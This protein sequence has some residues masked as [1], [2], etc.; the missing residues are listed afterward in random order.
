MEKRECN[1][2]EMKKIAK[3]IEFLDDPEKRGDIPPEKLLNML[4]VKNTDR[5]LDLGASTGYF[6]IPFAKTVEGHGYALDME[7]NTLDL[8]STRLN[9]S[10]VTS[11]YAVFCL[12][13]K[14]QMRPV[15]R[16]M[17]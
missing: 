8:K 2:N 14:R 9:S 17:S 11:S 1:A 4:P 10:H 12:K 15:T 5:M 7:S 3:K 6:T 16:L 13:I